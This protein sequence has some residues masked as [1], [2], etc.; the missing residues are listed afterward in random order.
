LLVF[1]DL[2]LEPGDFFRHRRGQL[3][4]ARALGARH[5]RFELA[6]AGVAIPR[7]EHRFGERSSEVPIRRI[8]IHL[9]LERVDDVLRLDRR[10]ACDR[11]RRDQDRLVVGR[12]DFARPRQGEV[13]RIRREGLGCH[14][15]RG[16]RR[17]TRQQGLAEI[18]GRTFD[19]HAF[20]RHAFD[21]RALDRR[22][23]DR[24][25]FN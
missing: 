23:L 5:R 3:Q 13:E 10:P 18:L 22:A 20:D 9:Q 14:S 6:D 11:R 24:R 12:H 21:R 17:W 25:A 4:I 16:D 7:V 15:R 8:L 2:R 19:R 1:D